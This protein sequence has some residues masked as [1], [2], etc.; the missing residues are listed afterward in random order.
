VHGRRTASITVW[1]PLKL[2]CGFYDKVIKVKADVAAVLNYFFSDLH[3]PPWVTWGAVEGAAE[4]GVHLGLCR[5][6]LLC[7]IV[8]LLQSRSP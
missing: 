5:F 1:K 3:K 7:R 6:T 8:M 4:R 2:V